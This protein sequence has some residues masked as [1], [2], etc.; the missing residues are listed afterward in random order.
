M[1]RSGYATGCCPEDRGS[2]PLGRQ[3]KEDN[4]EEMRFRRTAVPVMEHAAA[5]VLCLVPCFLFPMRT[6]L[7]QS[8][9]RHTA[10]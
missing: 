8:K 4:E 3:A 1:Y 10:R 2:S 6:Y 7:S 9:L 5:G